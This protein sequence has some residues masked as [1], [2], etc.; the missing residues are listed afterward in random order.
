MEFFKIAGSGNDFVVIDNSNTAITGRKE[1]AIKLCRRKFGVGA[2]G[3]LLVEHSK[4]ADFRMRIFNPDGSEAEMCGN[5]LRCI[6][7]FAAEKKICTK[8]SLTVETKAGVLEAFTDR[9]QNIRVQ[10]NIAGGADLNMKIPL[11]KT[12]LAGHFINTGVPHT[13]IEAADLEKIEIE[14]TGPL[15]RYHKLFSPEGT[16]ADWIQIMDNNNIAIRTY[17]RGVEAETL[18][19]GTGSVAGAIISFLLGKTASP[20][21]VHT[22]SG[23]ILRVSFDAEMKKVYLEGKTLLAFKGEWIGA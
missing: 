8:K 15:V 4:K 12:R 21:N 23:E 18:S 5:G 13:V 7:R 20:V 2:D 9:S 10:L 17:E 16:N 22:R 6:V 14:K 3:L 11:G 19:C 1:A